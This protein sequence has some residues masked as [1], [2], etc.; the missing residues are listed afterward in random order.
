MDQV[1]SEKV[2]EVEEPKIMLTLGE[3]RELLDASK[4]LDRL[5]ANGV[6]NWEGFHA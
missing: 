3:Y 1:E 5:Y 2:D 6:D 4:E